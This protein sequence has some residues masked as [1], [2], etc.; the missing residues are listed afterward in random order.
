[1]IFTRRHRMATLGNVIGTYKE[2]TSPAV[3][4]EICSFD[5]VGVTPGRAVW[6]SVL[7]IDPANNVPRD[8]FTV[9]LAVLQVVP[10]YANFGA[11][12][13]VNLGRTPNAGNTSPTTTY[14]VSLFVLIEE[15]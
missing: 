11:D 7:E 14:R 8:D 12:V 13:E 2:F 1:M 15:M 4:R 9:W 3:S 10:N 5:H 6:A